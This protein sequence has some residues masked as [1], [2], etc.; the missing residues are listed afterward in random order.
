MGKLFPLIFINT[1]IFM[2]FQFFFS[3]IF[4]HT[5]KINSGHMAG[6]WMGDIHKSK[7]N[8]VLKSRRGGEDF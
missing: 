8:S 4:G 6:N 1:Y 5:P 2:K 3:K 7:E